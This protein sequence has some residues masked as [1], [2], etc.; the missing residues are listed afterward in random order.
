M[1]DQQPMFRVAPSHVYVAC[2]YDWRTGWSL[3]VT[4]PGLE[5]GTTHTVDYEGLS[6]PELVDV[7]SAELERVLVPQR[8]PG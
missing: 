1:T 2:H 8:A 4:T 6:S 7:A 3:R 5:A